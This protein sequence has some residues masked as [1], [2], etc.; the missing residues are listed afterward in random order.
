MTKQAEGV[1]IVNSQFVVSVLSI[2][3]RPVCRYNALRIAGRSVC[4][5]GT[6][7]GKFG[8]LSG[9]VRYLEAFALLFYQFTLPLHET[10]KVKNVISIN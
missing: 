5:V 6:E 1:Y 4:F 7:V 8:S 2:P 3:G 10:L 9:F